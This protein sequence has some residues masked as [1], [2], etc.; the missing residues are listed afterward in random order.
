MARESEILIGYYRR[1]ASNYDI[2]RFPWQSGP[3]GAIEQESVSKVLNGKLVLECG[4]GSGR[5]PLSIRKECLFVGC[6]VSRE[7]ISL[8]KEKLEAANVDANLVLADARAL[9][10]RDDVFDSVLC[11]R[12]FKF[13][14]R[15]WEF[16][17]EAKRCL[18]KT[19]KCIISVGTSDSFWYKLAVRLGLIRLDDKENASREHYYSKPEIRCLLEE[20]GFANFRIMAIGNVLFGLY[21]FIWFKIYDKPIAKLFKHFPASLVKSFLKPGRQRFTSQVLIVC[22]K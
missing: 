16:L 1:T 10:I 17:R 19:G 11:S 15:P 20:I 2:T 5:F 9:P 4:V 18:R 14:S 3:L 21:S 13:F 22:D 7:M 12:T 6:D 8:C